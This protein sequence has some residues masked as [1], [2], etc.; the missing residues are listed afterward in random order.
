MSNSFK[1]VEINLQTGHNRK[2]M[3]SSGKYSDCCAT[4]GYTKPFTGR[5]K[6]MGS[7]D[8]CRYTIRQG[9][10]KLT[11]SFALFQAFPGILDLTKFTPL[12]NLYELKC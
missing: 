2:V 12:G 3:G 8:S 4:L 5:M 6:V 1:A 7:V 11:E 9:S 10:S